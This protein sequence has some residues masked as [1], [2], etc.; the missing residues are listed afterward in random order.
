MISKQ[1][2]IVTLVIILGLLSILYINLS[3]SDELKKS[4]SQSGTDINTGKILN[5]ASRSGGQWGDNQFGTGKSNSDEIQ[6]LEFKKPNIEWKP[7]TLSGITYRFGEGN[8]NEVMPRFE[9]LHGWEGGDGY[10]QGDTVRQKTEHLLAE[11]L[12]N[13]ML[14]IVMNQCG[15]L[16]KPRPGITMGIEV[17]LPNVLFMTDFSMNSMITI[18]PITGMK[19]LDREKFGL[20]AVI[21]D[22]IIAPVSEDPNIPWKIHLNCLNPNDINEYQKLVYQYIH[23]NESWSNSSLENREEVLNFLN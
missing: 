6:K 21:F 23:I 4:V 20:F 19:D 15:P 8:P 16:T 13:P 14:M 9:N 22:Q 1:K 11:F 2:Y 17:G 18:N 7:R 5:I 10:F 12:A 3:Q